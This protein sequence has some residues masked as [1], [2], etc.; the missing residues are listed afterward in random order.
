MSN[1]AVTNDQTSESTLNL[2]ILA[3]QLEFFLAERGLGGHLFRYLFANAILFNG[4]PKHQRLE[5]KS[6]ASAAVGRSVEH[7]DRLLRNSGLFVNNCNRS[8]M[9]CNRL[10]DYDKFMNILDQKS[11]CIQDLYVA[12][13]TP[14]CILKSATLRLEIARTASAFVRELQSMSV[15]SNLDVIMLSSRAKN[16]VEYRQLN[17][18][19]KYLDLL[20]AAARMPREYMILGAVTYLHEVLKQDLFQFDV[21]DVDAVETFLIDIIHHKHNII[22]VDRWLAIITLGLIH[23]CDHADANHLDAIFSPI[24]HMVKD[25]P[26]PK[27]GTAFAWL[28]SAKQDQQAIYH[29]K[30]CGALDPDRWYGGLAMMPITTTAPYLGKSGEL[31][32][33]GLNDINMWNVILHGLTSGSHIAILGALCHI[34][35]IPKT[36]PPLCVIHDL[37]MIL[38]QLGN[39]NM[40]LIQS[41]LA[42][43]PRCYKHPRQR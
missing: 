35:H 38:D 21:L 9:N 4:T 28:D 42:L 31:A 24:E 13:V 15:L 19:T 17:D 5:L 12:L 32:T 22:Y 40:P 37:C 11:I 23:E 29:D 30:V 18:F 8:S 1:Y 3:E 33:I 26:I 16:G 20:Y 43:V 41:R 34:T 39:S 6:I 7:M 14:Q 25:Q 27:I 2:D 36:K 10:F